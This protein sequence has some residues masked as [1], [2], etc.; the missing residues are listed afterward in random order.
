MSTVLP[1]L[2]VVSCV[3]VDCID[4]VMFVP[5][6]QYIPVCL[7]DIHPPVFHYSFEMV[8]VKSPPVR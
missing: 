6:L 5:L 1:R 2:Y 4:E 7:T 8:P 3:Q